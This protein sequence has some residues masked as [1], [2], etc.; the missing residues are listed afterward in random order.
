MADFR[1]FCIQPVLGYFGG[2]LPY[3]YYEVKITCRPP[4][5]NCIQ[6]SS[7]LSAEHARGIKQIVT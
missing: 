5:T 3:I 1:K 7:P 4:S 6:D 2:L